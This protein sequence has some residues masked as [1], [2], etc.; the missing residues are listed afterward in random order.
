MSEH[1]TLL[2]FLLDLLH[3]QDA[4]ADF[5]A[6]PQGA[7]HDAGLEHVCVQDIQDLL[8]VVLEKEDPEKCAKYEDDCDKG[9]CHDDDSKHHDG[10]HDGHHHG[11]PDHDDHKWQ[12]DHDNEIDRVVTHLNYVTNNYA[13]DSHDTVYNTNNITK[14]W[15]D[16]GAKVDVTNDTHNVGAGGVSIEG[17]NNAPVAT[18][19]H[20]QIGHDNQQSGDGSTTSFGNGSALSHVGTGDGGAI[21]VNGNATGE[22]EHNTSQA[23]GAGSTVTSATH[24]PATTNNTDTNNHT[25]SHNTLDSNNHT[26]SHNLVNSQNESDSSTHLHT[27]DSHDTATL[28]SDNHS[29]DVDANHSTVDAG[30]EHLLPLG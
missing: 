14:I 7:L 10:H 1:K 24:G 15:A 21:A 4:L 13:F 3:N 18:G 19:G 9:D 17:D 20:N 22:S 30:G 27:E 8:P 6:D 29:T 16:H 25:D 26:D 5:K 2:Q 28:S 23:F 11:N 12:H